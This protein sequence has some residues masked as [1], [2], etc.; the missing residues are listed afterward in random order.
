V[1]DAANVCVEPTFID[2]FVGVILIVVSAGGAGVTVNCTGGAVTP[3][4]LAVIVTVPPPCA[5]PVAVALFW[6]SPLRAFTVAMFGLEL[7]HA[8]V[9]PDIETPN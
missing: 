5:M 9:S 3:W 2:A 6:P 1:P 4:A 8:N 7:T